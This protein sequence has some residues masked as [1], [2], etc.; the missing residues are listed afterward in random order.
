MM[1][2]MTEDDLADILGMNLKITE[3]KDRIIIRCNGVIRTFEYGEVPKNRELYKIFF[4][5]RDTTDKI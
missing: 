3:K 4:G 5:S 2:V 1:E